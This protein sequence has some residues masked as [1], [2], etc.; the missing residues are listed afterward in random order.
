MP[1]TSS[2]SPVAME[3]TGTGQPVPTQKA[4]RA[5]DQLRNIAWIPGGV[6]WMG[7]AGFYPGG[8]PVHRASVDLLAPQAGARGLTGRG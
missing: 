4:A 7:S 6:F 5:P 3:G 8:C 1:T 2:S